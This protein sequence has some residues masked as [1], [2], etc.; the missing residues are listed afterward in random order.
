MIQMHKDVTV[1]GVD[2]RVGRMKA[3]VGAWIMSVLRSKMQ[4]VA[5]ATDADAAPA[6]GERPQSSFEEGL[7][8]TTVFLIGTLSFDEMAKVQGLCLE[9]C[10]MYERIGDKAPVPMPILSGPG[11]WTHADMEYDGPTVLSLAREC[12]A[13]NIAPFFTGAGSR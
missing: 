11:R 2:Y 4:G 6:E 13:F 12:L 10:D 7:M 8:A 3:H 9:R 1:G 5:T